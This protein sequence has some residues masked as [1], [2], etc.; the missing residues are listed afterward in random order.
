MTKSDLRARPIHHHNL[1]NIE[2]HITIVFAALAV[3]R[4]LQHATGWTIKHLVKHLRP[5]RSAIIHVNGQSLV[6]PPRIT[7]E[8]TTILNR[9][10]PNTGH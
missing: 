4:H 1:D 8:T 10:N 9:I 5:L 3:A 6:V 2:A 7:E